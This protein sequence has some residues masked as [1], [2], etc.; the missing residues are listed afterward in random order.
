MKTEFRCLEDYQVGQKGITLTRT[1]TEADIVNFA[2]R[3]ADYFKG[4][5]DRHYSAKTIYKERV[6]HG[7]LG[8]SLVTGLLS[9]TAPHTIGRGVPGAYLWSFDV[10]YRGAIKLDDTIKVRWSIA[11]KADDPAHKGYG[12]VRTAYEVVN[13]DEVSV[14]DGTLVTLVRMKSAGD[15]K[16]QLPPGKLWEVEEFVYDPERVYYLEDYPI[17]RGGDSQGRT[18]T[19]ADVVAFAGLTGDY[20][21]R[22][23]DAEFARKSQFGERIAH[24]MLVFDIAS[25]LRVIATSQYQAPESPI[26]GHLGDNAIFLAPVKIGDTVHCR[27]KIAASRVSKSR[28]EAGIITYGVQIVNQRNEV[29][30]EGAIISM[31]PTRASARR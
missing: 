2:C 17:G 18:V 20:D 19:E 11:D 12:L 26:A 16:L 1:V 22:Y 24:G 7:P 21:P 6:A 4:H 15:I 8:L 29:V 3:T 10:N 25:G 30:M 23:V 5:M 31:K 28:P 13:Q 27:Y 14:Y 9:L